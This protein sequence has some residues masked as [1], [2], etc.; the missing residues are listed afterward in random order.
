MSHLRRLLGPGAFDAGCEGVGRLAIMPRDWTQ[1]RPCCS[2]A[3]GFRFNG[4]CIDR[5][6]PMCLAHGV[7]RR[8]SA[9]RFPRR[10]S[11]CGQRFREH[12]ERFLSRIRLAVYALGIDVDQSHMNRSQRIFQSRSA[13]VEVF[14]AIFGLGREPFFFRTPINI[15]LGTPD[16]FA[17]KAEAKR[18]QDPWIHRPWCRRG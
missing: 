8:R 15:G 10:S 4:R 6:P 16:V 9:R 5:S 18:F 7:A 13:G 1:P 17:A 2:K 14:L 12:D 11:P 3:C